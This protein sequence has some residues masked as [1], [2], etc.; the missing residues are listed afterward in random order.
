M[1]ES[2]HHHDG[3]QGDVDDDGGDHNGLSDTKES[4]GSGNG[5]DDVVG[6]AAEPINDTTNN[7][8][9]IHMSNSNS[10]SRM[11]SSRSIDIKATESTTPSPTD[12]A[13]VST[14]DPAKLQG[15]CR[16]YAPIITVY[17]MIQLV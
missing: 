16:C 14:M 9:A 12:S 15:N 6:E 1:D 13:A 4:V 3:G 5:S 10:N 17:Y 2:K 11:S 8:M 7:N